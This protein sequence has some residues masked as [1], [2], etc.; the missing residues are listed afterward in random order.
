M[1]GKHI[2]QAVNMNNGE[3]FDLETVRERLKSKVLED[4]ELTRIVGG[5]CFEAW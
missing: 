3:A 4:S 2:I 1:K 5:V